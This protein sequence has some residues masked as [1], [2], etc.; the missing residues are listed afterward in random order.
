MEYSCK[1][2]S[3]HSHLPISYDFPLWS[4]C[5]RVM[6]WTAA[7]QRKWRSSLVRCSITDWLWLPCNGLTHE[8][9]VFRPIYTTHSIKLSQLRTVT[10]TWIF[11][12][13]YSRTD[14]LGKWDWLIDLFT[15]RQI[16]T[17]MEVVKVIHKVLWQGAIPYRRDEWQHS[18]SLSERTR[19]VYKVNKLFLIDL[20][21]QSSV[22]DNHRIPHA[23]STLHRTSLSVL[24]P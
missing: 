7:K 6:R 8:R 21:W 5:D 20:Y 17:D 14:L 23:C 4:R 19:Q 12:I 9:P 10:A 24:L 11:I 13:V 18:D 1:S 16:F 22:F 15:F 3:L 2:I